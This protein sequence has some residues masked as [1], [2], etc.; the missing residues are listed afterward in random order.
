[1]EWFQLKMFG[2]LLPYL[3]APLVF[4]LVQGLK[5][6]SKLI[7]ATPPWVKQGLVYVIAQIGVFLQSWSGNELACDAACGLMDFAN[8]P[9]FIKGVLV[10]ASTF[11][12]H[13]LKKRPVA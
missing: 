3:L 8:A 7:D 10:T 2:V 6:A 11:L 9:N 12:L 1:M 5:R 4:L 13:F